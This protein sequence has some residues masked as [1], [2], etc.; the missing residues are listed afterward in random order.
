M[1]RVPRPAGA[2]PPP[3]LAVADDDE[4]VRV[5]LRRILDGGFGYRRDDRGFARY[6]R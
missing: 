2:P 6:V 3:K 1:E 4:L 5:E